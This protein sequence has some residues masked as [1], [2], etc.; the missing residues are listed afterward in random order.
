MELLIK[1][2]ED[3]RN[4]FIEKEE[5]L[6]KELGKKNDE[7]LQL[8]KKLISIQIFYHLMDHILELNNGMLLFY[9]H[10]LLLVNQNI[11]HILN[12]MINYL[13]LFFDHLN[14]IYLLDHRR[15]FL[16]FKGE[17]HILVFHFLYFHHL[18]QFLMILLLLFLFLLILLHQH[19]LMVI[20]HLVVV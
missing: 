2:Y 20:F 8:E 7:I 19:N 14:K 16:S 5:Y 3:E 18:L 6:K 12:K 1:K 9:L 4:N 15:F 10:R 17:L 13:L 11:L